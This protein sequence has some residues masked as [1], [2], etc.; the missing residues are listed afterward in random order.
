MEYNI[1]KGLLKPL[2]FKGLRAKYIFVALVGFIIAF[3]VYLIF[4]FVTT[5]MG[6][7]LGI[8]IAVVSI[9]AAFYL[10]AKFGVNGLALY[11]ASKGCQR[12][13]MNS[14]RMYKMVTK[15]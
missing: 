11:R 1:N 8:T 10:N 3:L 12:Y 13:M 2:E 6:L 15:K 14:K 7:I 5:Y 4:S 9:G